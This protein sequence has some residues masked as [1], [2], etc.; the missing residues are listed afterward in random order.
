MPKRT[1]APRATVISLTAARK[2]RTEESSAQEECCP[3]GVME[4]M[5][6]AYFHVMNKELAILKARSQS[7]LKTTQGENHE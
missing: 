1:P 4:Q 5:L 7:V 2:A 3:F 6:Y